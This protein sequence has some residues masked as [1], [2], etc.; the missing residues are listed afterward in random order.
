MLMYI[1][2][3]DKAKYVS[4]VLGISYQLAADLLTLAGGDA[5]MVISC[6][7]ATHGLDQC[8]A[9]IINRRFDRVERKL[10]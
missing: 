3:L 1:G 4:K 10:K 9:E 6:S 7:K 5:D 2:P 8:K